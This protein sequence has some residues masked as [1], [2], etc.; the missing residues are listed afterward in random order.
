MNQ[1]VAM[2]QW[3]SYARPDET[4]IAWLGE[5][6]WTLGQ[7]RYDVA[8]LLN[9]LQ[10]QPAQRWAL[11][12]EDSYLF[13]VALLA[14]LH[15]HKTPVIPGHHRVA[16][17]K[18]QSELFEGVLSDKNLSWQGPYQQVNSAKRQLQ[19]PVTFAAFAA[20]ASVE[21]FTSG[22][23]G[24]A[25]Q[26]IKSIAVLDR[27][28]AMLAQRFATRLAG[29]RVVASVMP[30]HL[31]GLTFR[32][33]LPMALGLPLHSAMLYYAEQLVAL[34]PQQRYL[35][36]SSPAFLKRLDHQ[37]NP[38]NVAMILSAGSMLNWSTVT[39]CQRWFGI[40]PDEIYGSTETGILAWR[41]RQHDDTAWHP[42]PEVRFIAAEQGVTV[43]SPLIA[44][45]EPL[46]LDDL[47]QFA[48]DGSFRLLG[49]RGR[50]VK[51][52]EKRISLNEVE[53]RLLALPGIREAAAVPLQRNGRQGIG[54]L[55]VLDSALYQ[56]WSQQNKVQELAWRSA[57]QPWL[58]PVAIPRYWRVLNE[59]P[60]NSMNK[61]VDAQL[62]EL[63]DETK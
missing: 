38:P 46:P 53:Q 4:P 20:N 3:L 15:A 51:I 37:L 36:I 19:Q 60:V 63:F 23:T 29:C 8:T 41:Q 28:S 9:Y 6:T 16:L 1:P 26:V 34:E 24:T 59:I 10:Q 35:F 55:L 50:V 54:A 31:Y 30:Q 44:A 14:T 22:S 5:H 18:E 21:L 12:F 17:L 47:L 11:C 62:Q 48:A 40:W 32:I 2:A 45:T 56:Q 49:R 43:A 52:E 39:D 58:E 61:R 13:I 27:E 57:L 33:C 7:L 42:F 25:K